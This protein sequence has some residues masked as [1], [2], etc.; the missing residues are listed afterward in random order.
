[1]VAIS[2]YLTW[3]KV[4]DTFFLLAPFVNFIV[5]HSTAAQLFCQVLFLVQLDLG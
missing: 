3:K 4:P 5:L 1:M 2:N